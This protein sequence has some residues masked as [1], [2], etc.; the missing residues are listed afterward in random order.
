MTA[1]LIQRYGVPVPRYTSY[2]TANHFSAAIGTEDYR[3]W[4]AAL[5]PG[6]SLSLYL[7]I[8][9]CRE[10]CH[11]CGCNTKATR[12]YRPVADYLEPLEREIETVAGLIPRAHGVSHIHWGGG[13]PNILRASDIERLGEILDKRFRLSRGMEF[14]VEID[15]R[16]LDQDQ[17]DAFAGIGVNRVSLGVQDFDEKVQRAIWRMQSYETTRQAVERFRD[18]GIGSINIDLVY[19]LPHQTED[20]VARTIERVLSLDP[21]RIAIFGYA[22]L[23]QRLKHQRLIDEAALPDAAERFRQSR[24]VAAMLG[25]AG[26]AAIGL[27]HFARQTDSL[28]SRPLARNFQ[29]YTTDA[30]GALIGFGASAISR[31]PQGFAQNEVSVDVYARRLGL[32]GL[33]TARGAILKED[34]RIRAYVIERLMCDFAI[35]ESELR[36][37][38]GAGADNVLAT[39]QALVAEDTDGLVEATEDGFRMTGRGRPF[40]RN[41]CARFDAYL[42]QAVEQRRHALAV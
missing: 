42:P 29:G 17:V 26:F 34:D 25:E 39:A 1:S 31:L 30:A 15:A 9:Y 33:A 28:S 24:R 35:S 10:L 23:P 36:Y 20:S 21:D 41:I 2:P 18:K 13:S 22:H 19:G 32:Y 27:D 12:Q 5:A 37:R 11:Y 8:P 6:C 16:E 38:F 40:V 14:A 4:L 7:H 3:K